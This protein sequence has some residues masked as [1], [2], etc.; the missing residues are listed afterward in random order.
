MAQYNITIKAR[1]KKLEDGRSFMTFNAKQKDNKW[2]ACKFT[3]NVKNIPSTENEEGLYNIVVDADNANISNAGGYKT[4]W[5][6]HVEE[7]EIAQREDSLK[8]IF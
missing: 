4:L 2:I 5:I 8:D 3:K 7:I 6:D 1:Y